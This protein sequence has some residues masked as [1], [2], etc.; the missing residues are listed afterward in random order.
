[1]SASKPLRAIGDAKSRIKAGP[2]PADIRLLVPERKY[3]VYRGKDKVACY[4]TKQTAEAVLRGFKR[5]ARGVS[6]KVK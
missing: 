5:G 6:M 2:P 4:R 1:V 3:C